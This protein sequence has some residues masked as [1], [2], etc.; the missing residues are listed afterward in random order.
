MKTLL[1]KNKFVVVGLGVLSSVLILSCANQM[2]R[3]AKA[4]AGKVEIGNDRIVLHPGVTLTPVDEKKLQAVLKKYNKNLY[5]VVKL[6]NGQVKQRL[7]TNQLDPALQAEVA[8]AQ[9]NG[10]SGEGPGTACPYSGCD[11]HNIS[12]KGK[13]ML[14]EL[15][16]ILEHY[17]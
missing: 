8:S 9:K 3:S 1:R 14:A 17:Q 4:K 16:P 7:G 13:Q 10:D 6:E 5:H 2:N 12:A 11:N 15:K